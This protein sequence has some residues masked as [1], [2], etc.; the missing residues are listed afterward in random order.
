M[1]VRNQLAGDTKEV[2]AATRMAFKHSSPQPRFVVLTLLEQ[3]AV[4]QETGK[5]YKNRMAQIKVFAKG[6][7]IRSVHQKNISLLAF[8]NSRSD[9]GAELAEGTKYRAAFINHYPGESDKGK[10]LQMSSR[11]AAHAQVAQGFAKLPQSL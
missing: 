9:D 2:K 11:Y 8:L 1:K 5:D 7:S 3:L 4:G 10:L 6:A